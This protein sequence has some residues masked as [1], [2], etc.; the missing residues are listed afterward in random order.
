MKPKPR[1]LAAMSPARRREIASMGG[2]AGKWTPERKAEQS[3]RLKAAWAR[4]KSEDNPVG[5]DPIEKE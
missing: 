1:G 2:K 5:G 4:A 3:K